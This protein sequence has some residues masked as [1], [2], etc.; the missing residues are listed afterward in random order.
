MRM[1]ERTLRVRPRT[2]RCPRKR[3]SFIQAHKEAVGHRDHLEEVWQATG[4]S[5]NANALYP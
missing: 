3:V 4:A 1:V 5:Q 2:S